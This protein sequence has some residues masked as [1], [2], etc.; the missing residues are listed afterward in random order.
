MLLVAADDLPCDGAE[1]RH[2][3]TGERIDALYLRLDDEL[4]DLA[5]RR[6][7]PIGAEVFEVAA[8]GGVLPGQRARATAWP[9]TRPCT[10]TC[11]S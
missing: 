9:T 7:R 8:A 6:G 5:T 2:R 1:V 10:A 4:V 11:R 3:G